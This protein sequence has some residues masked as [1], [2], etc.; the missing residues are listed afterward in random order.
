MDIVAPKV[1]ILVPTYNRSQY[2]RDAVRSA[3]LQTYENIE[4]LI[5]DD[6]S[7]DDTSAVAQEFLGDERVRYIRHAKNLGIAGNWRAGI[8]M[9]TG[10]YFCILHDDDTFEPQFVERLV[11]PLEADRSLILAFCDHWMMATDGRRM[12]EVSDGNTKRFV[13][14]ALLRGTIKDWRRAALVDSTLPVGATMFRRSMVPSSFIDD[15]AMGAID[16][17]L[18]YQCV[19]TGAGAYYEP[20]RLMNYRL[21][22]GGMSRNAVLYMSEGHIYRFQQILLDPNMVSVHSDIRHKL[23]VVL[24]TKALHLMRQ[25]KSSDAQRTLVQSLKLHICARSVAAYALVCAGQ[26]GVAVIASRAANHKGSEP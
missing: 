16:Y 5:L 19:K 26:L 17:W 2:L 6:A 23:A 22:A 8:T 12:P 25:G 11:L 18:F 7:P 10:E 15:R 1:T 13:R 21:H 3:L 9:A 4:M 24:T 14:S 20:E